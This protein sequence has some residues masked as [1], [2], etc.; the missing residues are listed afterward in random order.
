MWAAPGTGTDTRAPAA[1]SRASTTHTRSMSSSPANGG[2]VSAMPRNPRSSPTSATRPTGSTCGGTSLFPRPCGLP[3]GTRPPTSGFCAA[4]REPPSARPTV[5]WRPD[6][7]R[8]P[9]SRTSPAWPTSPAS[10]TTRDSGRTS[11]WISPGRPSRWSEQAPQASRRFRVS[12]WPQHSCTSCNA[13]PIT[14]CRHT[15]G[16]LPTTNSTRR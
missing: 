14:A 6:V 12:R 1:T 15:T 16:H 5:S 13:R 3:T 2:G 7:F 4:T 9:S 11:R 8:S 10:G